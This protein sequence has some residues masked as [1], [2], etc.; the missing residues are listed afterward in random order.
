MQHD[1]L[2][3]YPLLPKTQWWY[4]ACPTGLKALQEYVPECS[5]PA[6]C[7]INKLILEEIV[8]IMSFE[9]EMRGTSSL[10]HCRVIGSSPDMM[11]QGTWRG[12]PSFT[13]LGKENGRS[14]GCSVLEEMW[15]NS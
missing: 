3:I 11:V 6:L 14:P 1:D 8:F 15:G 5:E 7:M 2:V 13:S 9:D 12:C 10:Y 4:S